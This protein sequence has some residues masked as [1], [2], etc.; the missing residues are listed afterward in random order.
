MENLDDV[1]KQLAESK[2][3]YQDTMEQMQIADSY[4]E[5]LHSKVA[6]LEMEVNYFTSKV[7][8]MEAKAKRV[9]KSEGASKGSPDDS[10]R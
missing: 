1:R 6:M 10:A 3:L 8:A 7:E 9:A 2:E 5:L 4:A